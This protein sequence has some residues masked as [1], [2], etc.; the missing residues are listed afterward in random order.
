MLRHAL[1]LLE[2]GR[3]GN[4]IDAA[5]A[6]DPF[7]LQGDGSS[8]GACFTM[9]TEP[10]WYQITGFINGTRF[11]GNYA[12]VTIPFHQVDIHMIEP[13]KLSPTRSILTQ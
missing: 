3:S 7:A 11:S 9:P 2:N 1:Q 10:G 13:V 5:G 4:G 8:G 6:P 12:D